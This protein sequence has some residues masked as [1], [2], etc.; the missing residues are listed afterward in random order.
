MCRAGSDWN[1]SIDRIVARRRVRIVW[2]DG[3]GV[4]RRAR[5]GG[6]GTF[7]TSALPGC[8]VVK[9]ALKTVY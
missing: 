7:E 2:R 9:A 5:R 8:V 3:R 4:P 1:R 6:P